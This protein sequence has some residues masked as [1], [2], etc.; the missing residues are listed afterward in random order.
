MS[1]NPHA[2]RLYL[3]VPA[4]TGAEL[5]SAFEKAVSSGGVDVAVLRCRDDGTVDR[6]CAQALMQAAALNDIAFLLE[7]DVVA[8]GSLGVDGVH[9]TGDEAVYEAARRALGDD[10]I[11]GVQCPPERHIALTLGEAGADYVAFAQGPRN[12]NGA[13]NDLQEMLSWWAEIVEIPS[14]AWLAGS[15]EEARVLADAGADFIAVSDAVWNAGADPVSS[16]AALK[17]TL[18]ATRSAA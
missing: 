7:N 8:A 13:G 16:I 12:G 2:C 4:D 17:A 6:E 3:V 5:S 14:V 15:E 18:A 1:D 10:A 11:V 9:L